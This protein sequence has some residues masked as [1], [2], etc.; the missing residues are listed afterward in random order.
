MPMIVRT[1][2]I[3]IEP[4]MV[5]DSVTM[6]D[7]PDGPVTMPLKELEPDELQLLC[8]DFTVGVFEKAGKE[9]PF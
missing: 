1:T 3:E 7:P 4:F 8:Q 9:P 6:V 2:Q 5:P